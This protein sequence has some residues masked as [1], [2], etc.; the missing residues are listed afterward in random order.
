MG[1][2]VAYLGP[3]GTYTQ[4]ALELYRPDSTCIAYPSINAVFAAAASGEADFGFVPIENVIN[5]RVA[6]TLDNLLHHADTLKIVGATILPVEH[7]LGAY[8]G[9]G[10]IRRILSKDTALEQCSEYLERMHPHAE[11]QFVASTSLAMEQ[12]VQ[13]R[14]LDAAAIGM[15]SSLREH[16]LTILESNIGN[17]PDNKTRFILFGKH[18][19][20]PTGRDVTSLV[21]YPKRDRVKLL[22]D[23]LEVISV[24][25]NLNMTDIDRRPDK[26]GLSILYIDIEGHIS[27]PNVHDCISDI[28]SSLT[29]TDVI[30]LGSYPHLPFNEPLI[31]TIG[32]I[33]GT[34][35]MGK[36]FNPFFTRLGY[37][38]LVAGRHTELSHEECARRADAVIVNVPIEHTETVIRK[39]CPLL[40]AGQLLVDNTG[41]KT[42][43]VKTML[44]TTAPAVEVLSIHTMF[45][46]NIESLRGQ[47]IISIPTEKSGPMA[48]EF[49]DIL[50]KHGAHITRATPEQH[51]MYVTFTQGLEHLDGVAKLATIL[52]L[53]GN[54]DNLD[55]FSTPNS[56]KSA[57]TYARIHAGDAHLYATMLREN[58]FILRTLETYQQNFAEM[59]E[60][61]KQGTTKTFE[62]KMSK[63]VKRLK[64]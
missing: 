20:E 23:M 31:R 6:Q 13:A 21:I 41:V 38:V 58:P 1:H 19:A 49:E 25:H 50:Y 51:D 45:G 11:L 9:H 18:I 44:A 47:N 57:E 28:V 5:G 10:E 62:Q 3:L 2:K 39:I 46:P 34:G 63:N 37:E 14:L 26:K 4:R 54:P 27:D 61:L 52:E 24:K 8:P 15:E 16:G 64:K 29:D 35:E 7:A 56:R 36:F 60:A 59:V 12:I 43:P 42:L 55:S 22:Y 33:G 30:T 40:C 32:I 48:Q 53:V 17:I